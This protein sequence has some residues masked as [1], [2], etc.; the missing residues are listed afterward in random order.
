MTPGLTANLMV[1]F[2]VVLFATAAVGPVAITRANRS[3]KVEK[4]EKGKH[5]G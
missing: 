3:S 1:F 4:R 5:S 2:F